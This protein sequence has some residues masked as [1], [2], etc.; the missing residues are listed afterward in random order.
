MNAVFEVDWILVV[1]L[2]TVR[3][4]VVLMSAPV[5]NPL[6]GNATLRFLFALALGALLAPADV[7][8]I[9]GHGVPDLI[10]A[11]AAE[12][13]VGFALAYGVI[14]AFGAFSVAGKIL[15]VQIGIGLG[16]VYDPVTRKSAPVLDSLLNMVG[17]S[18]FYELDGHVAL[19]EGLAYSLKQVPLGQGIRLDMAE[20]VLKLFALMFSLAVALIAPVMLA[21]LL[22]EAGLAVLA[23]MLPQMNLFVISTPAK[24]LGGLVLLAL[25]VPALALP[26]VRIYQSIFTFWEG[27]VG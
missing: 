25:S 2:T 15:D 20:P 9:A 10:L 4:G 19:V 23:K 8:R 24:S 18:V 27:V 1:M 6:Q 16:N 21:M 13:L 5:F 26:M 11:A 12:G 3:I 17:L 22:V 14:M 7:P